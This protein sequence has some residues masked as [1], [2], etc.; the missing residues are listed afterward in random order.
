[1]ET[2]RIPALD[3]LRGIAIL[4][5]L[6][7]HSLFQAGF[8][9]PAFIA[10]VG[11]GRLSWSGVDLFFVLSGFLIGGI[12]LDHRDSPRYFQSFYARR[13]YRIL[14]L[15]FAILAFCWLAHE[16]GSLGWTPL[17]RVEMFSGRLPWWSFLTM[18]QN[19]GMAATGSF[20]RTGLAVTWSLAIEEQFYLTLPFVIRRISRSSLFYL[21]A[22]V[23]CGAP[24]LRALLIHYSA[25]GAI[26]AYVL[27]TCRADS[28]AVG[29]LCALL[30]RNQRAWEY[31]RSHRPLI[32]A[33]ASALG[34]C[35]VVLIS[36]GYGYW[37]KTLY[38]LDFSV[39]ACF[40]AAVLLIAISGDDGFVRGVLCNPILKTLGLVAYG[41]YLLHYFC[42]EF[43]RYL[44]THYGKPS[45]AIFIGAQLLGVVVAI[46][47]AGISWR[48]F[49]KPLLHKGRAY[50]Y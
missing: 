2:A 32:Y 24:I 14:P 31:L 5:V 43:F 48:W 42:I 30:A 36:R 38:G 12:L 11:L 22:A 15:Y 1:L 40:Y 27:T 18:L 25:H 26:A 29:V 33:A 7:W 34:L 9:H 41:T 21:L 10:V 6:L 44:A 8:R 49:E 20:D 13:A 35:L 37:D 47:G 4:L 50:I 19:W 46:A 45:A 16:F 28:L 23:I 39:L 3:G 17:G